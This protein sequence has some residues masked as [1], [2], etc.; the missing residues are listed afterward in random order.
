M[1]MATGPFQSK[2]DPHFDQ[3]AALRACK[4]PTTYARIAAILKA[5]HELAVHRGTIQHFVKV[6]STRVLYQLAVHQERPPRAPDRQQTIGKV[7]GNVL[8][9]MDALKQQTA[10]LEE[11]PQSYLPAD[12]RLTYKEKT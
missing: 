2:L 11:K 7:P 12:G 3:I 5:Q 4:P 10:T 6:R 9:H 8:A 1:G